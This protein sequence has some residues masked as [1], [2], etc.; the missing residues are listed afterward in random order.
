MQTLHHL[1][2]LATLF[3]TEPISLGQ[4]AAWVVLGAIPLI[5]LELGKVYR[6]SSTPAQDTQCHDEARNFP[7]LSVCFSSGDGAWESV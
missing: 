5:V 2:V 6:Q 3:G 7:V 1:P 4:C